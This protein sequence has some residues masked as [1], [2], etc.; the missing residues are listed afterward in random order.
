MLRGCA[1]FDGARTMFAHRCASVETFFSW[2]WTAKTLPA[3]PGKSATMPG[4]S[5]STQTNRKNPAAELRRLP[6]QAYAYSRDFFETCVTIARDH[7][8]LIAMIWGIVP[9]PLPDTIQNHF[10]G[11]TRATKTRTPGEASPLAGNPPRAVRACVR[12]CDLCKLLHEFETF[13]G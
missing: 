1:L 11:M 9:K 8:C 7:R 4:D 10:L 12:A 5:H 6:S 3:A 2:L 13:S